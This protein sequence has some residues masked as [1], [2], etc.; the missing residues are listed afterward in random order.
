VASIDG[1]RGTSAGESAQS[2]GRLRRNQGA[3]GTAT[4]EESR[5]LVVVQPPP[6]VPPSTIGSSRSAASFL[7]HLIA[8]EQRAP[9]T[10]LRRRIEPAQASLAYR[11][12]DALAATPRTRLS[13]AC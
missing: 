11:V 5:A 10:R 8:T 9:Q 7:A 12:A 6:L 13:K 3:D 2:R 1:I 4:I